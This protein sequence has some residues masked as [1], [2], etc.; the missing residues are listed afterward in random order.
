MSKVTSL[1]RSRGQVMEI[2]MCDG[3]NTPD[4]KSRITGSIIG[5][6]PIYTPEGRPILIDH[7]GRLPSRRHARLK[8]PQCTRTA[9]PASTSARRIRLTSGRLP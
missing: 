5:Q 6:S 4:K 1:R 8:I 9:V 2:P 7:R 3:T